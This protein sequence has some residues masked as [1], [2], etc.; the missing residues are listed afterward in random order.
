M[1]YPKRKHTRLKQYDYSL[2]GY[3][4]VTIHSAANSPILSTVTQEI[5]PA[6]A[7]IHL[8][9]AGEA[10]Q[11]QLLALQKR[12]SNLIIDK[13]VIMPN[14]LHAIV[15]LTELP[16]GQQGPT[17]MEAIRVFKSLATRLCNQRNNTP[18]KQIF[19]TSFY[20]TVLRNEAAYLECWRYIDENPLKWLLEPEDL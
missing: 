7:A 15:R 8:T 6:G 13:Y 11:Q 1:D 18:G 2:P 17:L 3:Y 10:V 5:C 19:Q 16:P 20:E 12:Y 9:A 4:Y 14:H